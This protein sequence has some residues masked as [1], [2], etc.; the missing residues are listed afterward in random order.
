MTCIREHNQSVLGV[1][2]FLVVV[3]VVVVGVGID[4]VVVVLYRKWVRR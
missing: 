2:V 1:V 3:V 4:I